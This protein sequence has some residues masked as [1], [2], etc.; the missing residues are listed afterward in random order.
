MTATGASRINSLAQIQKMQMERQAGARQQAASAAFQESIRQSTTNGV[1]DIQAAITRFGSQFP[2]EAMG[3]QKEYKAGLIEKVKPAKPELVT[4]YDAN[5]QPTQGW[6]VP[7]E[8]VSTPIGLGKPEAPKPPQIKEQSLGGD[9]WQDMEFDPKTRK[10]DIPFGKPYIKG[11]GGVNINVGGEG[12]Q[13]HY[14]K[15]RYKGL[16]EQAGKL[17]KAAET[18]YASK[19]SLGRFLDASKTSPDGAAAG[20]INATQNFLSTFGY[21]SSDLVDAAKMEQA[22]GDILSNKMAELGARGL[23]DK[24]MEILRMS[25]PR[26]NTDRTARA[27]VVRILNK[28][29]DNTIAEW[30]NQREGEAKNYPG[31]AGTMTLPKWR[32]QLAEESR[33]AKT[34]TFADIKATAADSGKSIQEVVAAL[35]AKGFTIQGAE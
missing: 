25:L 28:S 33:L 20:V 4:T 24:D 3:V 9:W 17:D 27:E 31:L 23:T 7:G 6:A 26:V 35:K 14:L 32:K 15:E 13:E 5:G 2:E 30:D 29:H 11:K 18:A 19:Q 12:G 22:I 1:P 34:V 16:A 21:T 8:A 10:H